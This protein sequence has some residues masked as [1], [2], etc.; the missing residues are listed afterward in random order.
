M[1]FVNPPCGGYVVYVLTVQVS[2]FTSCH[3]ES[4]N[5][6]LLI[7]IWICI[8]ASNRKKRAAILYRLHRLN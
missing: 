1:F 3:T 4:R 2:V 8:M 5:L 7:A 6:K